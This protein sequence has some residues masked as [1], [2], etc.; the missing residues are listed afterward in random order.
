MPAAARIFVSY[1]SS[2][3]RDKATALARDLGRVFGDEQVFLDKDDLR[4]GSAW[5]AEVTQA[6]G[7]RPVLLLLVTPGLLADTDERGR[8]RIDDPDDPV[9]RELQ[10][11]L[12]AGAGVIPVLCDGV[13]AAPPAGALPPPFDRLS[14]LTWRRL[15]AYDWAADLARLVADLEAAGLE[16]REPPPTPGPTAAARA[17]ATRRAWLAAAGAGVVLFAGA[18]GWIAWR[19]GRGGGTSLDG[20]WQARL[21]RGEA[22]TLTLQESDAGADAEPGTR[23][24]A[25]RSAPLPV[26]GREDWA[27]YRRFWRERTG[28]DL[29][30]VVYRGAGL[31]HRDPGAAPRVDIALQVLAQPG[32][33]V[34]DGGNLSAQLAP[35]GRRL[36]GRIWLNGEQRDWPATLERR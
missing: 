23:R 9:R 29:D 18:A 3:G 6:L 15:R 1:R 28:A 32:D 7:R 4:G 31:V 25:L 21:A 10:A 22:A 2:D 35:D 36:E 26:S 17:P 24:L 13:E 27:E 30:A 14:E 5:R 8:R 34:I 20:T 33:T 16:R 12:D 11:A 19:R